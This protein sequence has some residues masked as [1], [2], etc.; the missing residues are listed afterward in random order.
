M[1]LIRSSGSRDLRVDFFRGVALWWI[2]T[3]HIPGD[4]MGRYSLRSVSLCDAA[5]VFVLLAGFGAGKA[6]ASVMDRDGYLY[7]A[8]EAVKRAWTLYIAHIF[9]FVV[10]AAQVSYGAAALNRLNYLDESRL[11]VLA[12]QPYDALLQA[13]TLRYQPSL[14]NILPLYVVLLLIFAAAMP[15]LRWPRVLLGLSL[16]TYVGVRAA[17]LNLPSWTDDGWFFNPLAWQLLFLIGAA[18]AYAPPRRVPGPPALLD[19]V[20]WAVTIG[21]LVV[22]FG[23]WQYPVLAAALPWRVTHALMAIDKTNL[24]PPRLISILALLWLTVRLVP[25]D[26]RW[27]RSWPAAPLVLMGQHSLPV[28][29][30]GIFIGFFGRL[31]LEASDG[32]AMQVL[33]NLGGFSSMT[34]VAALAAWY[35]ERGRSARRPPLPATPRTVTQASHEPTG[36][37]GPDRSP[38][39]AAAERPR[40]A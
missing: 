26:A 22:I 1:A 29:C 12:D 32:P 37:P 17:G 28:F 8:A 36:D 3:D 34:A 16:A 13:L 11:N 10:Y 19:A 30:F 21:G 7:G 5:E 14:L 39:G 40:H 25:A 4:V 31:G 33:V 20:S 18:L 35:G 2:F 15:L 6:Y 38:A 23:V 24:D 9:L 27:L